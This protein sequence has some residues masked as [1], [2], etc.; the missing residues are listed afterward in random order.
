MDCKRAQGLLNAYADGELD[1][2]RALEVEAHLADCAACRAQQEE[3]AG[4]G[5]R[6]GLGLTSYEAPAGLRRRLAEAGA[7]PTQDL[8]AA[9]TVPRRWQRRQLL[10][11]AASL[12][13]AVA[14]G[15]GTTYWTMRPAAPETIAEEVVASHIRSLMA[16][17][18]ID[19][20]SSDQHTVKP[21]FDGRLDL[22][23]SVVD[24]SPQGFT[25]VGGRLDYLAGEPVA[26]IVYKRAKHLINVFACPATKGAAHDGGARALAIRGYNILTWTTGDIAY[27]AVSDVNPQELET[28]R[29]LIVQ[30][31][32][33]TPE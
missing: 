30:G 13:L 12:L 31:S 20:A 1:L 5:R 3:I 8:P 23:P 21:W 7:A 27:W 10:S 22:A 18:L 11:L 19:I 14:L 32:G 16:E 25:L 15:S 24:L 33:A 4:L 2:E 28:L 9:R 29:R 26:A 6:L 17:H